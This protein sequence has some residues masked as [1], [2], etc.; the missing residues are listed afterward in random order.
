MVR[1][2]VENV[3]Y[4]ALLVTPELFPDVAVNVSAFFPENTCA[5]SDSD[6]K[7]ATRSSVLAFGVA[8]SAA[9][10][11]VSASIPFV[12]VMHAPV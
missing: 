10:P 1:D 6:G 5:V 2:A 12:T 8:T 7:S 3:Q 9:V 11:H 4:T